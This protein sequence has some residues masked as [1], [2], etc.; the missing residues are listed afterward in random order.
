MIFNFDSDVFFEKI[1]LNMLLFHISTKFFQ[2][3]KKN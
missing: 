2:N 1:T 3:L